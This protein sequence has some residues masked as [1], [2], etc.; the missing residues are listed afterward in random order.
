MAEGIEGFSVA[1]KKRKLTKKQK[2]FVVEYQ[3]DKN[4]TQ[5]AIRAGF[6]PKSAGVIGYELLHKTSHVKEIIDRQTEE[7]LIRKGYR[8]DATIEELLNIAHFDIRKL[9]KED[10]SMKLPLEWDDETAMAVGG[11]E[12]VEGFKSKDG[13]DIRTNILKKLK[14]LDKTKA[15]EILGRYQK[16]DHSEDKGT[17]VVVVLEAGIINKPSNSGMSE[18]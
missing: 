6:S 15:L 9:Y 10:G 3:K 5:A 18:D 16:L 2:F 17:N 13:E 11:L 4:A 1:E 14:M 8:A 7:R 12:V